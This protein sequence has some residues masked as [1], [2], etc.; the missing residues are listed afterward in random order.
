M[1]TNRNTVARTLHDLGAAAW[2]GGTLMGAIGVNGAA[3]DVR[4]P[5]E[6]T[7]VAQAGWGRWTPVNLAA[8]G[9][10]LAGGALLTWENKGR[11]GAQKGV[12]AT[13]IAKT[14]VTGAALGVTA[15]SRVLGEQVMRGGDVPSEGG[16]EPGV[17]T[18]AKVAAAQRRLRVLQWVTPALTGS[19]IGL[20]SYMGEQQRP[21]QVTKGLFGRSVG[22]VAQSAL[23][24]ILVGQAAAKAYATKKAG[25]LSLGAVARIPGSNRNGHTPA[26]G[27][28]WAT[29]ASTLSRRRS[30][31]PG[32]RA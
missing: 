18:P 6:A 2:F 23:A 1:G 13:T 27:T 20:A 19:I 7:R 11:I 8:I 3:K 25:D 14:A 26:N 16:T 15:Y 9:A 31:R 24:G 29:T 32:S 10:H 28:R 17:G 4:D 22:Q 5:V 21:T 30:L 12:L